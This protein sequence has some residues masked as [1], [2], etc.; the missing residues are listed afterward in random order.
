MDAEVHGR[1]CQGL[2]FLNGAGAAGAGWRSYPWSPE[3]LASLRPGFLNGA[4]IRWGLLGEC[5]PSLSTQGPGIRV[6]GLWGREL[7][8]D[9]EGVV[10]VGAGTADPVSPKGRIPCWIPD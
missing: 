9:L 7:A 8:L 1:H 5:W 2:S 3:G 4:G 10:P 6:L